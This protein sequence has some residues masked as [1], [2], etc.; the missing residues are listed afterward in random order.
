MPQT[1]PNTSPNFTDLNPKENQEKMSGVM[2]NSLSAQDILRCYDAKFPD[3]C[4]A[5]GN[6]DGVW[7]FFL[8]FP[9]LARRAP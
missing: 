8:F 9:H 7:Y 5:T 1:N 4:P 2:S 3:T 6:Q